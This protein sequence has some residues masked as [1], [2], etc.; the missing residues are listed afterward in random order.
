VKIVAPIFATLSIIATAALAESPAAAPAAPVASA[1]AA[2]QD[3]AT[4]PKDTAAA[5]SAPAATNVVRYAKDKVTLDV[6]SMPAN[7]LVDEIAR[8]AGAKVT[9][10]AGTTPITATWT[11]LPLKDALEHMLG[12]QNFTLTY[13]DQGELRVIQL[14]GQQQQGQGQQKP[15]EFAQGPGYIDPSDK[16]R[17]GPSEYALFKALDI[18]GPIPVEGAMAKRLGSS[19]APLDQLANTSIQDEDPAVRK[20]G[21]KAMMTMLEGNGALRDQVKSTTGGMT[22]AALAAFARAYLYHL[23]EDFVHNVKRE[24]SDPDIRRRAAAVL[25]ELRKNPYTGPR[26]VEGRDPL[27]PA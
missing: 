19:T 10:S 24:T 12:A 13:S 7:D 23:A 17:S 3:A 26:P 21:M 14:R 1:P 22:D 20:S 27:P 8:Q 5:A 9:G 6:K 4:A 2:A 15:E 25:R 18:R 11:D 16:I